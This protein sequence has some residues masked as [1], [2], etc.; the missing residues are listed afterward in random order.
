MRDIAISG[1]IHPLW[2]CLD[3]IEMMSQTEGK[4]RVFVALQS[5]QDNKRKVCDMELLIEETNQK[6]ENL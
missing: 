3:V 2:K 4:A 6:E 5:N 1:K